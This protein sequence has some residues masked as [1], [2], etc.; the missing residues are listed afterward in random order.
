MEESLDLLRGL[1]VSTWLIYALGVVPL[2]VL[3]LYVCNGLARDPFASDTLVTVSLLLA[4]AFL[5]MHYCQ[6]RFAQRVAA[7]ATATEVDR[8][9]FGGGFKLFCSQAVLQGAK[10]VVWPIALGL[11]IPHALATMFFQHALAA[12]PEAARNWRSAAREAWADATYRQADGVWFL[13]HV[14]LL[15]IVVFLNALTLVFVALFLF[16]LFTGVNNDLTRAPSNLFNPATFGACFIAAYI[17]LDPIVKAACVLRSLER[18]SLSSGLDLQLRLKRLALPAGSAAAIALIAFLFGAAGHL[19]AADP[20]PAPVAVPA[21]GAP[22]PAQIEKTVSS[23]FHDPTLTWELPIVVKKK[24]PANAFLAFTDSVVEKLSE[25]RREISQWLDDL[26]A[27]LR[28]LAAGNGNETDRANERMATPREVWFLLIALCIL[29][30]AGVFFAF[31]RSRRLKTAQI[32]EATAV[33]PPAPDITREDVQADEQPETMWLELAGQYRRNGDFRLA[34][35]ALYLSCLAALASAKL[36]S[37]AR[38]KSNLDYVREYTRRAKRLS[39]DLP[40]ALRTNVRLFEQSWYGEHP[41]TGQIL[42]EFERNVAALRVGSV[43]AGS[44]QGA[45]G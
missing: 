27:R 20:A 14:L 17:A 31:M 34:L 41:V 25:W 39:G 28:R 38:G 11:V 24:K 33:P 10:V 44:T 30:A 18:R 6:A 22:S 12:P 1:S 35:R 13:I 43:Q 21:N 9:R 45:A 40:P 5:W 15:R 3:M 42:D 32:V 23:V 16:H 19:C 8:G 29:I 26:A 36:I 37:I 2:F 4:L 7:Y